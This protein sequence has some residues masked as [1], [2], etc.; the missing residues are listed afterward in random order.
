MVFFCQDD[1]V[2]NFFAQIPAALETS[3]PSLSRSSLRVISLPAISLTW[4]SRS[5]PI[6]GERPRKKNTTDRM[7]TSWYFFPLR[8]LSNFCTHCLG[9]LCRFRGLP[10]SRLCNNIVD[11]PRSGMFNR[12]ILHITYILT[13]TIYHG[14]ER[15][16]DKKIVVKSE[17]RSDVY[18]YQEIY[19]R[20]CSLFFFNSALNIYGES[21]MDYSICGTK[22]I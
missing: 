14:L 16:N 5:I 8:F 17:A 20:P 15:C 4:A 6:A 19:V 9:R 2:I 7:G 3:R 13:Y 11:T 10:D 18:Y 22:F 1:F 12:C 21:L